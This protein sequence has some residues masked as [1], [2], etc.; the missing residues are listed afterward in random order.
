MSDTKLNYLVASLVFLLALIIYVMTMAATVSFWDSGEFIASSYILG[1]PHSPGTPMYILV[2]RVFT[3]LPLGIS[4]AQ[5]VNFLSALCGALGVLMAYLVMHYVVR[6]MFKGARD[7]LKKFI[8]YAGPVTGSLFLTFSDTYWWDATEA[9]V[10]ALSAFVMGLC[11]VLALKW[12]QNPAGVL[13]KGRKELIT[14]EMGRQAGKKEISRLEQMKKKHSRNLILLIIY[15]LSL[16]IGFH[17]GT[18]LV[19]GGVF[20][21][22]LLVKEKAISN[23]ELLVFTFGMAV[24]V[25]DMT[26]YKNSM[27][28]LVGLL[29]FMVLLI[30]CSLSEGRFAVSATALFILGI[31]VH[32]YL[33]IR[34]GLD[35]AIDEV[36]PENWRALYYVLRREQYPPLHVFQRKASWIFQFKY[37]WKYFYSQFRMWGDYSIGILNIGKL[38]ILVPL[39]LGLYGIGTHYS[40]ER[41]SWFLVFT[42]FL[43]NS[44]GLIVFLN[45]SD[46]EVRERDY[47]YSG[48]FY[49]FSIFIGIGATSLLILARDYLR[50]RKMK[51]RR[52]VLSMGVLLIICAVLPARYHWFKHDRSENYLARDYAFNLLAPLEP[53]AIIF[54]NGDNDTFPLWY[55]QTVENFRTDVRVANLSLLETNWYIRQLRDQEPRIPIDMTDEEIRNL[56]PMRMKNGGIFW[57]RDQAV[58]KIITES[59][60]ERPVY[61]AVTVPSEIWDPYRKHLEMEGM[62]RRLVDYRGDHL[63]NE[64]AMIRGFRDFFK[65]RGVLTEDG[66]VDNSIYKTED[67]RSMFVNYSVAAFQIAQVK[68][69]E[70][71]YEDAIEWGE[72]SLKFN[73]T[74]EWTRKYLGLYYN[75]NGQTGKAIEFY[76]DLIEEDPYTGAYYAGL[77]TVYEES[78][79]PLAALEV[80]D[81]AISYV[82]DERDLY[83]YGFQISTAMGRPESGRMY[84]DK[85]LER[86]P[87]DKDFRSLSDNFMEM[88]EKYRQDSSRND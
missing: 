49:F 71:N 31:S 1:I 42:S 80:V 44:L 4:I 29:I 87:G 3:M 50:E 68:A 66:K 51:V 12:Y 20:I 23:F 7:G 86:H 22:L 19:Y 36:D 14:G 61:F 74:F 55:I 45:F 53:D 59:I 64:Y 85:W 60:W 39:V 25:A 83:V 82:P 13:D 72:L 84:I 11:V 43:L 17:L 18:I 47:F 5:K 40:R 78:G 79:Q 34:S 10:Y 6:L 32:L 48:A 81:R 8:L 56:R 69:S 63:M 73:E 21:L 26:L 35:P 88:M 52:Y 24:L 54:T 30:W 57:R 28:T 33:Y 27:I 75:R 15:L 2:G 16:G 77:I 37:F 70:G 58:R 76:K 62:V 67:T 46:N 41:R 38:S 65:Y 9:E